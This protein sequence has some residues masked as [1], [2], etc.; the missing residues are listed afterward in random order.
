LKGRISRG[1]KR[2]LGAEKRLQKN[3]FYKKKYDELYRKAKE[4]YTA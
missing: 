2:V 3:S 4:D 1:L